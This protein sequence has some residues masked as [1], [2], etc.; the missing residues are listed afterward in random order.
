MLS[1]AAA[2]P[3]TSDD[4]RVEVSDLCT[5]DA[6]GGELKR[7]LGSEENIE[8][9]TGSPSWIRIFRTSTPSSMEI[10]RMVTYCRVGAV[11]V[12]SIHATGC[13]LVRRFSAVS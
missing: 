3:L 12:W 13:H 7:S 5:V 1:L 11:S 2:V 4:I 6:S 8:D 10:F 9:S